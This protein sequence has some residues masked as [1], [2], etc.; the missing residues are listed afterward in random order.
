M[1]PIKTTLDKYLDKIVHVE[2]ATRSTAKSLALH[3]VA[4]L[5][6]LASAVM[7]A[8]FAGV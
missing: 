8:I 5:F 4:V 7:A 3:S 1:N 2:A 6:L